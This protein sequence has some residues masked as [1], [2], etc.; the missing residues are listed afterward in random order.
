M[1]TVAAAIFLAALA[2]VPGAEEDP[3]K[4]ARFFLDRGDFIQTVQYFEAALTKNP[5]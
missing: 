3:A 4:T 2:P 1:P 5:A